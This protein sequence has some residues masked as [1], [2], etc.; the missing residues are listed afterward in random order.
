M[1]EGVPKLLLAINES[2]EFQ[3][4]HMGIIWCPFLALSKNNIRP[5]NSWSAMEEIVTSL[6][7]NGISHKVEVIN[8]Q[9]KSMSTSVRSKKLYN[10][11]AIVRAFSYFATPRSL[12]KQMREDYQ[13]PSISILTKITFSCANQTFGAFKKMYF[14][15][16]NIN[17]KNCILLHDEIYI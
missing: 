8:H 14:I 4:F 2:L 5:Q 3:T 15:H 6:I 7:L 17:K 1:S 12:Y 16:L 9:L 13:F 10:P 11:E